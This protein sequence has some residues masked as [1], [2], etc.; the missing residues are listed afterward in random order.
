M[1]TSIATETGEPTGILRETA[2]GAVTGVIP[3]PTHQLRRQGIELALA[4]LAEHGVTSA[5]DYS[6]NW[7]N[8]QIYEELEK[9][10]KLTARISEWLPFDDPIDVLTH[11]RDSHP[12]S[13]SM[14]HTGMLKGF[15]DGSLVRILRPLIEPYADD[16]K[17]S[18]LP[19]L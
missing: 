1:D 12:Q 9:E 18:G 14:L 6:P 16:P 17:N 2:Q 3:K 19:Q 11:K 10:G 5:Q 8:F 4:D 15:M 13:D 7:D